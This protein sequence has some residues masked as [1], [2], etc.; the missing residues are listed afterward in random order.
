MKICVFGLWHLGCVTAACLADKGFEVVGLDPNE[1]VVNNLNEGIPPIFEP[2][3]SELINTHLDDNLHFTTDAES[4]LFYA[5]VIWVTFD[6]P[7]DDNDNADDKYVKQQIMSIF[8]YIQKGTT[9]LISS[10]L[11]VGSTTELRQHYMRYSKYRD[12]Y[13]AY[14]PENLRLGR[15]IEVFNNPE[16][17][18][19]GFNEHNIDIITLE[20]LFKDDFYSKIIWMSSESAEMTKHA[21]NSFLATEVVFINEIA[22]LCEK[23]GAD[24]REVERGLKS[25]SRVGEKGYLKAGSAF[26]GGTLARDLKFLNSIKITPLLSSVLESNEEHKFWELYILRECFDFNLRGKTIAVLGLTYKS[27]TNTLRRS[28]SIELCKKLSQLNG[29]IIKTH[30]PSL[31]EL[32]SEYSYLNLSYTIREAVHGADAIIIATGLEEYKCLRELANSD[33]NIVV[34]DAN[35]ILGDSLMGAKNIKYYSVGRSNVI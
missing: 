24:I 16:R 10:Q 19:I 9:L 6:T 30:D 31:K 1:N 8:P 35:N 25:D 7:V 27:D 13:F 17:I 21:L 15:A 11:P 29:V 2:G 20:K 26:S 3:L 33:K 5:D 14:S 28:R 32:P 12:V 22:T 4:A 23:T 18:V 34:I